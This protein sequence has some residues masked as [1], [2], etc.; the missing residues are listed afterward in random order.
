[1]D[2]EGGRYFPHYATSDRKLLTRAVEVG[3]QL[4]DFLL[5]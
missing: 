5:S 3:P 2:D 4:T 1:M